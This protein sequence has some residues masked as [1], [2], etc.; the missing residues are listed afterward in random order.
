MAKKRATS[1][2]GMNQPPIGDDD[3]LLRQLNRR[4]N[5][6]N[7]LKANLKAGIKPGEVLPLSK[8]ERREIGMKIKAI[9]A[10]ERAFTKNQ[11]KYP[12]RG[13]VAMG[14]AKPDSLSGR[15]VEAGTRSLLQGMKSYMVDRF[16]GGGS[17]LTG[18]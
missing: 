5:L 17:R 15:T 18:R 13:V 6:Q 3:E 1:K 4:Q 7:S 14:A 10:A 9:N 8:S 12:S 11:V 2:S 16:G